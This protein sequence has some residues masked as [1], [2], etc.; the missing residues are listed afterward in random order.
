MK[1]FIML[2]LVMGLIIENGYAEQK[3]VAEE[4]PL[5]VL[6]YQRSSQKVDLQLEL[7]NLEHKRK[8]G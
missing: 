7:F 2:I 5:F 6:N 3:D 1:K 4:I 8:E